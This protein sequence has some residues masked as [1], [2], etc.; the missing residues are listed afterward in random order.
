MQYFKCFG[1]KV[2]QY[3]D[4]KTFAIKKE[5]YKTLLSIVETCKSWNERYFESSKKAKI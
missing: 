5:E 3:S 1:I 2:Q 4:R